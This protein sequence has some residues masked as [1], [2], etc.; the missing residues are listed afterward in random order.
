MNRKIM[1]QNMKR[2]LGPIPKEKRIYLNIDYKP[3]RFLEYS[4]CR[5]DPEKKLWF[6]G[7]YHECL[8]SLIQMYGI[9]EA[10]SET[11]MSMLKEKLKK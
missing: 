9:H 7:I 11:A 2:A 3:R 4:N 10:T 6:T 1:N 5:F 8:E